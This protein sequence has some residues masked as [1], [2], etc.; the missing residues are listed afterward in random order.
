MCMC[1]RTHK[2]KTFA[3]VERPLMPCERMMP[4]AASVRF[5]ACV[6]ECVNE[7]ACESTHKMRAVAAVQATDAVRAHDAGGCI[8]EV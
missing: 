1:K 7:C 4:V 3:A 2:M 8:C 5:E 6:N